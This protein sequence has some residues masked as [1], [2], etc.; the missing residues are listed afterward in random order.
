L[1]Y[2]LGLSTPNSD[3]CRIVVDGELYYWKDGEAVVFDGTYIHRAENQTQT[4]RL[5][6]FGDIERPLSNGLIRAINRWIGQPLARAAATQIME[7]EKVGV[8][9]EAFGYV[10]HF[11]LLTKRIKKWNK[12]AYYCLKW[13]LLGT[14]TYLILT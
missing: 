14:L 10:Y 5:I 11:R 1:R 9:N 13:S 6:L 4:Q 3:A 2:H 7:G 8:L 12:T